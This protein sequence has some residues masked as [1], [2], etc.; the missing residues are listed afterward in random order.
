M[1]ITTGMYFS[2][3]VQSAFFHTLFSL[4]G[5][6]PEE[7]KNSMVESLPFMWGDIQTML[8]K[9]FVVNEGF[10]GFKELA[11]TRKIDKPQNL[12]NLNY[13]FAR[14]RRICKPDVCI[15]TRTPVLRTQTHS[16]YF[17]GCLTS[18]RCFGGNAGGNRGSW[19]E[20][21]LLKES[22]KR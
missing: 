8:H 22:L 7:T 4:N 1:R 13:S 5:I 6:K 19:T 10:Y 3:R 20:S 11:L 2:G 18:C 17:M 16:S 12:R 15:S 9:L 21:V 14:T